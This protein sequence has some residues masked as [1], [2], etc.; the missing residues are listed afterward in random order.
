MGLSGVV[1]GLGRGWE[2]GA[3]SRLSW[4]CGA[5]VEAGG[6]A[7][8]ELAHAHKLPGPLSPSQR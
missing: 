8:G 6:C 4:L 5:G 3:G 2:V 1:V 7:V